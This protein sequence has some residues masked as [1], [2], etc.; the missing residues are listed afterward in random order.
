MARSRVWLNGPV[1][2]RAHP[3]I[4]PRRPS[5]LTTQI[6]AANRPISYTAA[7][8]D[9]TRGAN[10]AT[11]VDNAEPREASS[12][13]SPGNREQEQSNVQNSTTA[14]IRYLFPTIKSH[15][16]HTPRT[17]TPC[18][19]TF[20]LSLKTDKAHHSA[21]TAL[22]E[23][24]FPPGLN[25]LTAHIVLSRALPK[26]ELAKIILDIHP[27]VRQQH[28]FPIKVSRPF[29]LRQGVGIDISS[30]ADEARAIAETLRSKW[31]AFL[32]RQEDGGFRPHYT[33]MNKV[34]DEKE[35][36]R[37]LDEVGRGFD[38]SEGVVVGLNFRRYDKG[39][40]RYE[41]SW[42]FKKKKL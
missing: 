40:W 33:V 34:D 32:S 2:E 18:E 14:H 24:Y 12:Q 7:R 11:I 25:K 36:E 23:K 22:R 8:S 17:N 29:R 19:E 31:E 15:P 6:I 4:R 37:C 26:S 41:R 20:F 13:E 27:L 39:F 3:I 5:A 1:R 42:G 21:V 28:T 35:I 30:G 16:D 10:H 38:A 9:P